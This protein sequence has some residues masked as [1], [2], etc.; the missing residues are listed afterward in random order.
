MARL[1]RFDGIACCSLWSVRHAPYSEQAEALMCSGAFRRPHER[2]MKM[3]VTSY[4]G[5]RHARTCLASITGHFISGRRRAGAQ[6]WPE[7][8]ARL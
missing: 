4:T 5:R 3:R 7:A 6:R 1:A 2:R 8:G